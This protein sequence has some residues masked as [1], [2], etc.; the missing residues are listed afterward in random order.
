MSGTEGGAVAP[1]QGG[2][3]GTGGSSNPPADGHIEGI[4]G[5]KKTAQEIMSVPA[6]Q[7]LFGRYIPY[8]KSSPNWELVNYWYRHIFQKSFNFTTGAL[9]ELYKEADQLNLEYHMHHVATNEFY[10]A[11]RYPGKDL[12][13]PAYLEFYMAVHHGQVF[14]RFPHQEAQ[15]IKWTKDVGLKHVDATF[16]LWGLQAPQLQDAE[17]N[18]LT[19]DARNMP[20]TNEM[21]PTA[22][23][24]MI[25]LD[26]KALPTAM[27]DGTVQ[28]TTEYVIDGAQI[29]DVDPFLFKRVMSLNPAM[30]KDM[31]RQFLSPLFSPTQDATPW[32]YGKHPPVEDWYDV[33]AGAWDSG[34]I[35]YKDGKEIR[36]DREGNVEFW[37]PNAPPGYPGHIPEDVYYQPPQYHQPVNEGPEVTMTDRPN[38][39][40]ILISEDPKVRKSTKA[41]S[42]K[43]F[44]LMCGG[45]FLLFVILTNIMKPRK[46]PQGVVGQA[47]TYVH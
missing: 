42:Y 26:P 20:F 5:G 14:A 41:T 22:D 2:A 38:K 23:N 37:R 12:S 17:G 6:W 13:E 32:T 46:Y 33:S 4:F 28:L 24:A 27:P 39:P 34:Y 29:S 16:L 35:E 21:M 45:F 40:L 25:Y 11:M 30:T 36:Y 44:L 43:D 19:V 47:A 9:V 3:G 15:F 18:W 10:F 7:M 1:V 8:A 31:T